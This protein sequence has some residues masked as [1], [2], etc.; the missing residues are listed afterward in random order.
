MD[1]AQQASEIVRGPRHAT[2]DKPSNNFNKIA[3]LWNGYLKAK[4]F[5]IEL[6]KKD[7]AVMSVLIKV[8]REMFKHKE[9]NLIDEIGYILCLDEIER[10]N[11][12]EEV[13]S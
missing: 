4:G 6:N 11:A 13:S 8:A 5:D 12:G 10:E 9:D 2:Y 3:S 1:I 7:V